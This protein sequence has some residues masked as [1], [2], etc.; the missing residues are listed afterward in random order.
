M[1]CGVAALL[2]KCK[3]YDS[4]SFAPILHL[5]ADA[6]NYGNL[7]LIFIIYIFQLWYTKSGSA[8]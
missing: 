2:A 5:L 8:E 4:T 1:D 7:E 3:A 6:E